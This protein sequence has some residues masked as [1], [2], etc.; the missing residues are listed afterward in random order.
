MKLRLCNCRHCKS[1]RHSRW[2]QASI[3]RAKRRNRQQCRIKLIQGNWE[4]IDNVTPGVY[5]D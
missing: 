5:T 3:K 4:I 2:S 1:G